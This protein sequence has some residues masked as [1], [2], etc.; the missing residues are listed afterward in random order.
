MKTW[1]KLK[2]NHV[3][4][5]PLIGIILFSILNGLLLYQFHIKD[6]LGPTWGD[7]EYVYFALAKS[8]ATKFRYLRYSNYNPL[9]PFLTSFFFFLTK[10]SV[11]AFTHI[12]IFNCIIFSSVSIPIYLLSNK[13][14]KNTSISIL[15]A[16]VLSLFPWKVV[17][18]L[19]VAESLY[20]PMLMWYLFLYV[21]LIESKNI[22]SSVLL[23]ICGG[24]LFLTKQAGIVCVI[25]TV[26]ALLFEYV[27][28]DKRNKKLISVY[29]WWAGVSALLM[30]PWIIRNL[31]LS[32]SILGYQSEIDR[33]HTDFS[34]IA[35]LRSFL[36]QYSYLILASH[37]IFCSLFIVRLTNIKNEKEESKSFIILV[38]FMTLGFM[39][40]SA[41]HHIAVPKIPYGRYI[42]GVLPPIIILAISFIYVSDEKG[43]YLFSCR[44][45]RIL[46]YFILLINYF[47]PVFTNGITYSMQLKGN[48]NQMDLASLRWIFM[49]DFTSFD[50]AE[51]ITLVTK[52]QVIYISVLLL[53]SL[54]IIHLVCYKEAFSVLFGIP[55][56]FA[57]IC[58]HYVCNS[59][60]IA[61]KSFN[62]CSEV[63][64]YMDQNKLNFE[65]AYELKNTFLPTKMDC[66][67]I[68]DFG[69]VKGEE[70]IDTIT[71]DVLFKNTELKFDFGTSDSPVEVG[72]IPVIAPWRGEYIYLDDS[73]FGFEAEKTFVNDAFYIGSEV[74]ND[75]TGVD[76]DV[77]EGTMEDSFFINN[78]GGVYNILISTNGNTPILA[79]YPLNYSVYINDIYIGSIDGNHTE[80]SLKEYDTGEGIIKFTFVPEEGC[81]W[82]IGA[83]EL[84]PCDACDY[85]DV[86]VLMNK[87]ELNPLP[88]VYENDRF[89][90]CYKK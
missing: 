55:L 47:I 82:T 75:Q 5:L 70:G 2:A 13:F 10:D 23:G 64:R 6:V 38:L 44:R 20:F 39:G 58:G 74:V 15:L 59:E 56:F 16:I 49:S 3:C 12:K 4:F 18:N 8:I 25:A 28:I 65:D 22:R 26:I 34:I 68:G 85:S 83:L 50:S 36:S 40:L 30:L 89:K 43:W 32:G 42:T 90:I 14:F 35:L 46:I 71:Y 88:S 9:Y 81:I 78:G 24:A 19:V 86:Y 53:V 48:Y 61:A 27:V 21:L 76:H 7:D 72:Y 31:V 54:A 63:Y 80:L 37:I 33:I 60:T 66:A 87:S 29:M 41:L 57:V 62:A 77:I 17:T 67:W 51:N 45:N 73:L 69:E 79:Y 52:E 11:D 84:E 1:N